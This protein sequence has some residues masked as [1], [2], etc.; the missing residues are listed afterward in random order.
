MK[1]ATQIVLLVAGI[2]AI[3]CAVTFLVYSIVYFAAGGVAVMVANGTIPESDF[4]Q[5]AQQ[6]IDK[7]SAGKEYGSWEA[8]AAALFT[9]GAIFLILMIFCIPA[10]ILS[11]LARSKDKKG[12][13]ICC[14]IFGLLSSTVVAAAGGILG[15]IHQAVD[16]P[17]DEQQSE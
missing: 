9:A 14:I 1:K 11:F 2:L 7:I 13:Y 3:V 10:A 5:W 8:L 6:I 17:K 12:L 16:Q 4:P 15:L